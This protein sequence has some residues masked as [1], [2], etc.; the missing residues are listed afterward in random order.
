MVY[1]PMQKVSSMVSSKLGDMLDNMKAWGDVFYNVQNYGIYPDG[2]DVTNKLQALVNLANSEGRRAIFFPHGDYFVTYINNDQNILYFGDNARFV[3]GYDREINQVGYGPG[4]LPIVNVK[5]FGAKGDGITDDSDAFQSA[6]NTVIQIGGT[7]FIPVGRYVL[8]KCI[9]IDLSN[10]AQTGKA[11]NLRGDNANTTFIINQT[12]ADFAFYV[13]GK[14]F[15][16]FHME[17]MTVLGADINTQKG[18][19]ME[20]LS[21]QYLE[22]LVFKNLYLGIQME[23]VVRCKLMSCTF[24]QNMRG[25]Y[26]NNQ[27]SESTP[28]AIDFFGCVFYGN[29]E[30][31]LY[32]EGGCNI[33]FFGG[34]IETN[35]HLSS[36]PQRWGAKLQDLGRYGAA[37]ATFV[38]TY[39]EGNANIAD[40]WIN[41]SVYP[42]TYSF[43]G[44]TFN[45][46]AAP[47]NND[48]NI[49]VDAGSFA[50]PNGYPVKVVVT[51]C[52]FR[53]MGNTPSSSTQYI[54][55]YSQGAPVMFEQLGNYYQSQVELPNPASNRVFATGRL[56]N[57]GTTPT[58]WRAFNVDSVSK[59]NT[60][61]YQVNYIF[62]STS[63]RN[64][65]TLSTD[66]LGYCRVNNETINGFQIEVFNTS[67]APV[68]PGQISF[69]SCE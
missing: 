58:V 42:S 22:N 8:K 61:V 19:H 6:V 48:H 30:A 17:N 60:G 47:L 7:I 51:G 41:E 65:T 25:L 5:E 36:I 39:F 23:D 1:S 38:G 20:Y 21:E 49:R 32:I 59:I 37:G 12:N 55:F 15:T 52:A 43:I 28:N 29:A 54:Q 11:I 63:S 64:I 35:G 26:G 3:G 16:Y 50:G 18:L 44:C 13:K 34:T 33:N 53:D 14:H 46:F 31:G 4:D 27:I 9:N 56:V 24:D 62:P 40:V 69:I 68:D 57:L 45:R 2:T 67:G 10:F 66:I